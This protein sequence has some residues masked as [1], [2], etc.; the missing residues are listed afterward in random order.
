[1]DNIEMLEEMIDLLVMM[2]AQKY[3]ESEVV[4]NDELHVRM[5]N[6]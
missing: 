6:A 4:T 2:I 1:M 3:Q 5:G